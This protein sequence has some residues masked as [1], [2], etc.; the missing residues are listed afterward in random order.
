[1]A[2]FVLSVTAQA[3]SLLEKRTLVGGTERLS[4]AL[5]EYEDSI[6]RHELRMHEYQVLVRLD[7]VDTEATP[8]DRPLC[9][10]VIP[11][12]E[13]RFTRREETPELEQLTRTI[14]GV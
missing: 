13:Q 12:V 9:Q 3:G 4:S 5:M 14:L 2:T 10:A 1:M 7:L 8:V 6:Y 11:S